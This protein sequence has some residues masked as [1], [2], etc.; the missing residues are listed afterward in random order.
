M[1]A[2]DRYVPKVHPATR[3][4]EPEDPLTL[5]AT[6]VEGDPEVMLMCLVQEYA[7]MGWGLEEMLELFRDPFFPALHHL[8]QM[9]GEEGVRERITNCLRETA[10]FRC[11]GTVRDEPEEPDAGLVAIGIP[12]WPATAAEEA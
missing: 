5:N 3:P 2:V 7:W 11:Q 8:W 12:A 6:L 4:V 1:T 10:V 9:W